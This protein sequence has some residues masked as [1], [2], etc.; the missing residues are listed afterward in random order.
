MKRKQKKNQLPLIIFYISLTFFVDIL[1]P[2]FAISS[3]IKVACLRQIY[4]EIDNRWVVLYIVEIFSNFN[5]MF[6]VVHLHVRQ[7]QSSSLNIANYSPLPLKHPADA[8][9]IGDSLLNII[10]NKH[11]MKIKLHGWKRSNLDSFLPELYTIIQ[12]NY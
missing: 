4:D 7:I 8:C 3:L 1:D 10:I 12:S 5:E 6:R 11:A 9:S 2:I